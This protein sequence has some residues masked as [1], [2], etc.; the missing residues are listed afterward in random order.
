MATEDSTTSNA[1]E[2]VSVEAARARLKAGRWYQ[3]AFGVICMVMIANLQYGWTLFATP[4]QK[5]YNWDLKDIQWTFTMFVFFETWLVPIEGYLADYFGPRMVIIVGGVLTAIGWITN[6][7]ADSLTVLLVG[8]IITGIGAGAV[9]GT[10]IGNAL[11]W[12]PE[13]RGLAS[14]ITAAGFGFGSALTVFPISMMIDS[15]GYQK[16]FLYFGIGQAIVV[17]IVGF[18]IAKPDANA[19]AALPKPPSQ[20]VDR[21][22]FD[23][24]YMLK[25]PVFW[26][27]YVMFTLMALGGLFFVAN[28]KQAAAG[29]GVD[30]T[31]VSFLFWAPT[32]INFALFLDRIMNGLTR[33]FF[34]WVSDRIGRE[35][36]MF[37]AFA[38][39]AVGVVMLAQFGGNPVLFVV[40]TGLVFFGW[41]EIYSLFPST[42]TDTYGWKFA[43]GNAGLLYTAKGTGVLML[44]YLTKLATSGTEKSAAAWQSV[45][46]ICAA[47]AGVAAIM[48]LLVLK[49]MRR[50]MMTRIASSK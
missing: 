36:A 24:K 6:S 27:M 10:C 23:W 4:I 9:Y 33:P 18:F 31:P 15:S 5:K 30:K 45:F 40:L 34:G 50:R 46:L 35:N 26:V 48:A 22:Q 39:E 49:P 8:Q 37:V 17:F 3:L 13:K 7:M 44:P 29:F 12:F 47:M 16:T 25:T 41:G 2:S 42:C 14:G 21:K 1:N 20:L 28:L 11:K 19:V 38:F 43:T 32:A